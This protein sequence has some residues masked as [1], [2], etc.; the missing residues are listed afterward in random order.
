M[1]DFINRAAQHS[2]S[3]GG[4]GARLMIP[5]AIAELLSRRGT[6]GGLPHEASKEI[7]A[8]RLGGASSIGNYEDVA[9]TT[10]IRPQ[11]I[12]HVF[13]VVLHASRPNC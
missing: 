6:H 2:T 8:M 3:E 12:A 13:L 5:L 1:F 9:E 10:V 4:R 7:L 11:K